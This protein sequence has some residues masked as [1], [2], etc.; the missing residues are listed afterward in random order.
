MIEN[1]RSSEETGDMHE[2]KSKK[3]IK[4]VRKLPQALERDNR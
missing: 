3:K 4:S 1:G 2:T